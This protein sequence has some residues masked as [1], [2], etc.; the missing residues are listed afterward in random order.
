[1]RIGVAR[2]QVPF[3]HGGAERHAAALVQAL[4]RHGH[5]ATE[6]TL[7]FKWYPIETMVDSI[8]AATLI[9]LSSN[10]DAQIDMLIGLKFPAYLM[11]HH[12]PVFWVLHQ[13]R[14]AYDLWSAGDSEL[15]DHPKG[16]AVK[17]LIEHEER[18]A[19]AR[20][21]RPI[22]AN[23]QNVAKRLRTYLDLDA[24]PLY[25][26]PPLA[27]Q[28]YTDSYDGPI[29]AP[30]RISPT[31]RVDL[32]LQALALTPPSVRLEIAGVAENPAYFQQIQKLAIELGVDDRVSWLGGI[33]NEEMLK[34]YAAARAVLFTPLDEDYGYIAL[35]AMLASKPVITVTDAG[36]P[37]E[38]ITD[39]Q[40]GRITAPKPQALAQAIVEL[41]EDQA[42]AE[43]LGQAGRKRYLAMN[44]NWQDVV[45]QLTGEA[46]S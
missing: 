22:F 7:P 26:P 41:T 5:Q 13:H 11:A 15:L 37:L 33:S 6:I 24:I 23:S 16:L 38:F 21:K 42:L 35:E 19:F 9:D 45:S 46:A 10:A 20:S 32:M 27:D 34:H 8:Q 3:V 36:G 17:A 29:F 40:E 12:N 1:M 4:E 18:K 28:L 39:G 43:R 44:I 31:K 25:H 14:R 30:G 2:I